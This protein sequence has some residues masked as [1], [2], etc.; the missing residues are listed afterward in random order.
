[1]DM[2]FFYF[3]NA[4]FTPITIDQEGGPY[5]TALSPYYQNSFENINS[6]LISWNI[7]QPDTLRQN[8]I[9]IPIDNA[10]QPQEIQNTQLSTPE[11]PV[12]KRRSE[13]TLEKEI[14]SAKKNSESNLINQFYS[15]FGSREKSEKVVERC[16]LLQNKTLADAQ[17]IL[18]LFYMAIRYIN[19]KRGRKY[20]NA[21]MLLKFFTPQEF[22]GYMGDF[23]D[24]VEDC[25]FVTVS[26]LC[27]IF[28]RCTTY[29]LKNVSVSAI[30]T[31]KRISIISKEEHLKKRRKILRAVV[32]N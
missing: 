32:E 7:Q 16:C 23:K 10:F 12:K 13:K 14:V 24:K 19:A 28:R 25:S 21:A 11:S 15:F 26:E 30:L 6:H 31:S 3:C 20:V 22:S 29:F 8:Q 4:G 2:N 5:F 9:L 1:M 27:Q 17:K 18:P